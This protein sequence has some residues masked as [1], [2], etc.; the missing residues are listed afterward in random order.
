MMDSPDLEVA[1]LIAGAG[2]TG[3]LTANLLGQYGVPA[4][5]VERNHSTSDLP[6]AILLDDEGFR[7]LQA[8]GLAEEVHS[9]VIP[10]YGARYYAP[11]GQC[12]AEVGAPITENGYH[13][14]NA[15]LQP[16]LEVIMRR[17]LDRFDG[18]AVRFETALESFSRED[19]CVTATLAGGGGKRYCV[20]SSFLLACDGARSTVRDRL[21]IS[22]EGRTDSRDWVVIDTR[23]DPD[24]DRFSKF[25]CDPAR[26]VVSI[27]APGGGRRYEFMVLPGEDADTM[28]E[29]DCVRRVLAHVRDFAE[30]DIVR[31]A[32]YTFHSRVAE[33]LV[34]GPVALLGDAAHLSPPFAGQGMNAG[35]RD[36]FNVAWKLALCI[37]G[38]AKAAILDSYEIER[39]QPIIDMIDY[40]VA[41]GEIVMPKGGVDE[42][43]KEAIRRTLMG[44]TV[45][46]GTVSAMKP[47]PQAAYADGWMI[48][49]SGGHDDDL[50][51]HP[52]A[53]PEVRRVDGVAVRLDDVLGPWFAIVGVGG[54]SMEVI[55]QLDQDIWQALQAT[56]VVVLSAEE[57]PIQSKGSAECE[58]LRLSPDGDH[59][60]ARQDG[61]VLLVRPD[62]F[63]AGWCDARTVEGFAESIRRHCGAGRGAPGST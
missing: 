43:A 8:V 27:P 3:L 62:R 31:C 52:M 17:G 49:S 18:V 11:D 45:P 30:E 26:P 25:F 23:N 55:D 42:A 50:T 24:S 63:V 19:G 10:G 56:R 35:L 33:Q 58:I 7:A 4:L 6:K 57:P 1:V 28:K 9:H 32:V 48:N 14:R 44:G 47:K 13:R 16:D 5:L 36:A 53:Q 29:L 61:R 15:F 34:S 40:A 46:E 38:P 2:P 22:M 51:G 20:R 41:L 12:F 39:R 21:G 60:L 37:A 54:A 59:G